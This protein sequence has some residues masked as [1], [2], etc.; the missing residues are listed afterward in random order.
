VSLERLV[1]SNNELEEVPNE[2]GA[3]TRLLILNISGNKIKFLPPDLGA[4]ENIEKIDI[5]VNPVIPEIDKVARQGQK[6]LI[7]Y[8]KTDDY[9]QIYYR[10]KKKTL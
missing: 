7:A 5:S 3:L 10:E 8:L 1:V 4:L 6:A 9:D 2:V